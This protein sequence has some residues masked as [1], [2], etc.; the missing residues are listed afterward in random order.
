MSA[1]SDAYFYYSVIIIVAEPYL[2]FLLQTSNNIFTSK[3]DIM[4]TKHRR[5]GSNPSSL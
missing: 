1:L 2:G 4:F 5:L 3:Y